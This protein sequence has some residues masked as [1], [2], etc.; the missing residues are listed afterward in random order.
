MFIMAH[1]TIFF[2]EI[3][4]PEHAIAAQISY[5]RNVDIFEI[6]N[7]IIII[8]VFALLSVLAIDLSHVI[9][10]DLSYGL[11]LNFHCVYSG[12]EINQINT[13]VYF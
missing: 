8:Y 11:P 10:S 3:I 9:I 1:N 12:R 6:S 2:A 7:S 5:N 4:T 13:P